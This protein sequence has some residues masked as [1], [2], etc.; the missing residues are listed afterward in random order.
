MIRVH[1]SLDTFWWTCFFVLFCFIYF[2]FV[3]FWQASLLP[4]MC[5]LIALQLHPF[6]GW[7]SSLFG[8]KGTQKGDQGDDINECP[9]LQKPVQSCCPLD[10][11]LVIADK[12]W[13]WFMA[14]EIW[15]C[16]KIFL[17]LLFW[18]PVVAIFHISQSSTSELYCTLLSCGDALMSIEYVPWPAFSADWVLAYIHIPCP[19][20]VWAPADLWSVLGGRD[21]FSCLYKG[22]SC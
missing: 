13:V 4:E 7:L 20:L 8:D 6:P 10:G 12:S 11:F 19:V 3:C 17:L 22:W 16:T 15:F 21:A 1:A 2:L 5:S 18:S 9:G 14:F